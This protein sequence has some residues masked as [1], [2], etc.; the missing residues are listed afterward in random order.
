MIKPRVNYWVLFI[1]DFLNFFLTNRGTSFMVPYILDKVFHVL[2]S[3][4]CPELCFSRS[5]LESKAG[6]S[7]ISLTAYIS[8]FLIMRRSNYIFLWTRSMRYW[9]RQM[10]QAIY[11][12]PVKQGCSSG[13]LP[14]C[15]PRGASS[16]LRAGIFILRGYL[17]FSLCIHVNA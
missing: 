12:K 17:G 16:N 1:S 6:R 2:Y 9:W 3:Q 4:P 14:T 15:V 10:F 13:R 5:T 11:Y 7:I 8:D